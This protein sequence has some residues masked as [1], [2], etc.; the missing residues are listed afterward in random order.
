VKDQANH[1][2]SKKNQKINRIKSDQEI[3]YRLNSVDKVFLG[4]YQMDYNPMK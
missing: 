4:S 1:S 3:I 2:F